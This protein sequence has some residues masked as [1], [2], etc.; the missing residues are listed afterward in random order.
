MALGLAGLGVLSVIYH[1]FALVWQPVP[2]AFPHRELLATVSGCILVLGGIGMLFSRSARWATLAMAILVSSWLP[3]QVGLSLWRSPAEVS[4]WTTLAET[5]I[6]MAGGWILFRSLMRERIGAEPKADSVSPY[7]RAFQ[8]AFAAAVSAICVSHFVFALSNPA[9]VPA[10]IPFYVGLTFLTGVAHL[11]AGCGIILRTAARLAATLE[12]TMIGL[13]ALVLHV[14]LIAIQP[15]NRVYWTTLFI[16]T[17][18]S[19]GCF[20]VASSIP[21]ASPAPRLRAA[22]GV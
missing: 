4:A 3:L 17:A 6:L 14:P 5:V 11:A 19:G 12:A 22:S 18:C 10:W 9:K 20:V 13:F 8:L 1:S 15:T 21:Q 16:A 7:N 2:E